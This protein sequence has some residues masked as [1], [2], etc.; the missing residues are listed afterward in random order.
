MKILMVGAG[1]VASVAS[2]LLSKEK[3]ISKIIC[4]SNDLKR[5]K[6]FID[7]K[8]SKIEL[9]KIDASDKKQ[10]ARSARDVDLII[11]AS[12]PYF[13]RNIMEAA[14]M[15]GKNYQDLCSYLYDYKTSEQLKFHNRFQ[16]AKLVGLINTGI[17]P[18]VTNL[19]SAEI[20]DRL[21]S[22]S[23]IRI[24][25]LEEQKSSEFIF[26]WSP[27]VA[28]DVLSAPPPTYKNGKLQFAERYGDVEEYQFP[29]PYGKRYIFNA[30]GDEAVTIPLYIKTKNLTLKS[31]GLDN[32][33]V[34]VLFKLGLLN[35]KA[36]KVKS[37]RVMR[38][39][40]GKK[41]RN[42]VVPIE[43]LSTIAPK[44]PTPKEMTEMIRKGIIE[45][46]AFV[47][48]V[49][50]I[51]KESG[52]KI[53][54]KIAAIYPDLKHI[55]KIFRGATYISYPTGLAV[56]CFTKI[57][58]EIEEY[59]VFPPEALSAKNRKTMLLELENKGVII[60]EQFSKA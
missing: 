38:S 55:S 53:K 52:K 57:L 36:V 12:I 8:N 24:R 31:G 41:I 16:K 48:V 18:G 46:A 60:D 21:D 59:G 22:I 37:E 47:S 39:K 30:S 6:E 29:E 17:A 49:E 28:L 26:A 5:G 32:E 44:I 4:A 7:T 15:S 35:R 13:N 43:L 11:N 25:L 34:R 20:A 40:S 56:T 3:N 42:S 33:F 10:I 23:D 14:I 50:G 27:E 2:K 51:G 9:K 19:L 45:N 1:A 54:I 58:P